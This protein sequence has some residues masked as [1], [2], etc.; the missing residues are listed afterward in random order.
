MTVAAAL[1]ALVAVAA[2]LMGVGLMDPMTSATPWYLAFS[3]VALGIAAVGL[4]W[5]RFGIAA[6]ASVALTAVIAAH[7]LVIV[8]FAYH[9]LSN[10]LMVLAVMATAAAVIGWAR[11]A[12]RVTNE[13]PTPEA[14]RP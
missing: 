9:G 1:W 13:V 5:R 6:A 7:A 8:E 14:D 11:S 3:V 2:G 10:I 12:R 4:W